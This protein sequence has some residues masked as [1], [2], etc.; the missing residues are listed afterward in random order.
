MAKQEQ[1]MGVRLIAA[2]VPVGVDVDFP[3][4]AA[5]IADEVLDL[6]NPGRTG[7]D[8]AFRLARVDLRDS[9]KVNIVVGSSLYKAAPVGGVIDIWVS[10]KVLARIPRS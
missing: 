10:D 7:G 6:V 4:T 3:D 1:K 2:L 9:A 5:I 8:K